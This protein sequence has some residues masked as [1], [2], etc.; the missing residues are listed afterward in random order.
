MQT[1]EKLNT[2]K[3]DCLK[4]ALM[5]TQSYPKLIATIPFDQNLPTYRDCWMSFYFPIARGKKGCI[6]ISSVACCSEDMPK[7]NHSSAI[8]GDSITFLACWDNSS[9]ARWKQ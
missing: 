1:A 7:G 3:K 9:K 5:L 2:H 4:P 8:P 6:I